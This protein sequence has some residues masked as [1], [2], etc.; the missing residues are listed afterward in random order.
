MMYTISTFQDQ[1]EAGVWKQYKLLTNVEWFPWTNIWQEIKA[2]I[3]YCLLYVNPK[4][5]KVGELQM[6]FAVNMI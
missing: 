2:G 4:R 6:N 3:S 5:I 1:K